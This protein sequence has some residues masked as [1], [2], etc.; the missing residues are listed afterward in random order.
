MTYQEIIDYANVV[1]DDYRMPFLDNTRSAALMYDSVMEFVQQSYQEGERTERRRS[2][3]VPLVLNQNLAGG[4]TVSLSGVANFMYVF[5]LSATFT[6]PCNAQAQITRPIRPVRMDQINKI[7]IDSFEKPDDYYPVYIQYSVGAVN[8]LEVFSTTTPL[9]YK[10]KYVRTPTIVTSVNL[11]T[12]SP[13]GD[14]ANL[15]IGKIFARKVMESTDDFNRYQI[16][17][18]EIALQRT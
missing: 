1:I 2:D 13:F 10:M 9:S 15:E 12:N 5:N 6:D 11:G 8:T 16:E 7:L 3:L 14:H 17:Q 18:N 4:S